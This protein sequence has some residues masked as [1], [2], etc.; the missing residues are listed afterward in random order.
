MLAFRLFILAMIIVV[1]SIIGILF[2]KRY[3]NRE[4]E[5][6]EMKNAL[7]MFS[8]KIKFTY[9][10]IPNVFMEIANKIDGNIGTIF[11]VAAN[12]M[13]EM[14]AGEAWRKALLISKNNLNK[15]DVATIQNLSRLLGQTDIEGQ[16]SEVE[17]VNDFLT[18]QLENASEERRKNEKMY[19]TL[20][21]VTGLTIAIILIWYKNKG[22][23]ENNMDISLLF[24]IAAIGILVAV[25][26]QVLVRAGREDQAMMTTL[27][28]LII[29]LTLVIKEISTL[30]SSVRTMFG[31]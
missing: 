10:P 7:N 16:I 20:G 4:K 9:E 29:V 13:K 18:V 31:L 1:S 22:S 23:W 11:N 5:I 3:A 30:F 21:L 12:N 19:R 6:K 24:K 28:G 25:L 2:S 8:T 14:S 15:E 27:A 26:Y 17:V